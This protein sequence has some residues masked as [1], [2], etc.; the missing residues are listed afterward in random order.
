MRVIHMPPDYRL[1][2]RAGMHSGPVAS[3]VVGLHAPRYCLFGDAVIIVI[4]HFHFS[5]NCR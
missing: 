4:S 1:R 5:I 3:G 2:M